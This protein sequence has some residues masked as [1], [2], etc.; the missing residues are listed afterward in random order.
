MRLRDPLGPAELREAFVPVVALSAPEHVDEV[1]LVRLYNTIEEATAASTHPIVQF[2]STDCNQANAEVAYSLAWIGAALLGERV[3]FV[4]AGRATPRWQ[5]PLSL[6]SDPSKVLV[7]VA[8]GRATPE[9][10]IVTG[11]DLS[12][13]VA[14][15]QHGQAGGGAMLARPQIKAVLEHLRPSFDMIVIAPKPSLDAPLAAILKTIVDGSVIVVEAGVTRATQVGKCAS[16]LSSGDSLLI[17]AVMWR[18]NP[19]PRLLRRWF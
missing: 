11:A 16:L 5:A 10:A 14:T 9:E 6:G 15:L 18:K 7:D 2:V 1:E 17:G 12:L 19:I 3:L 13:F 4:D 8:L